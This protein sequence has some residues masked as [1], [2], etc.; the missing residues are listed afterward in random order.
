MVG[1]GL[2]E[3][4]PTRETGWEDFARRKDQPR[5]KLGKVFPLRLTY[6]PPAPAKCAGNTKSEF[7]NPKPDSGEFSWPKIHANWPG[8]NSTPLSA[9]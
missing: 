3:S 8:K 6:T 1:K 9:N 7:R 2:G 5:L 4:L